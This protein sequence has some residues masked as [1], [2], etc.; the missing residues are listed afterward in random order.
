VNQNKLNDA[1]DVLH[2]LQKYN[3]KF[4]SAYVLAIQLYLQQKDMVSAKKEFMKVI[5]LDRVDNQIVQLW[6]Q[7]SSMQGINQQQAYINLY[8]TMAKSLDKRGKH[9]EAEEYRKL[10]GR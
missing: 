5:D 4:G 9:K 8:S 2:K 1:L 6:V 10:I 3:P 7:Y